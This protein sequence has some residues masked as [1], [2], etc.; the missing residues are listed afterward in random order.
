MALRELVAADQ[1]AL[2]H[3]PLIEARVM[4]LGTNAALA[5][6]DEADGRTSGKGLRASRGGRIL[7]APF[8]SIALATDSSSRCLTVFR[9]APLDLGT[10][11]FFVGPDGRALARW[12]GALPRDDDPVD[13]WLLAGLSAGEHGRLIRFLLQTVRS[14]FRLDDDSRFAAT[15]LRLLNPGGRRPWTLQPRCL[16]TAGFA[17]ASA[18]I[19]TPSG[20]LGRALSL[21]AE[22]V[23]PLTA[24]AAVI[25]GRRPGRATLYLPIPTVPSD[26]RSLIAFPG[27]NGMPTAVPG[28]IGPRLPSFLGWLESRRTDPVR[29]YLAGVLAM[30]GRSDDRAAAAARE[31][32]ICL[33]F[34]RRRAAKAKAPVSGDV[35][36]AIGHG[37]GGLFL[38]GWLSDPHD[39]VEAV[40]AVAPDGRRRCLP[41]PDPFIPRPEIVRKF[42]A[43]DAA[44]AGARL[45]FVVYGAGEGG[46]GQGLQHRFAF[47]LR[48][49]ALV[50]GTAPPQPTDLAAARAAVLA[51][52]PAAH[53]DVGTLER[54]IAPAVAAL[55]ARHMADRPPATQVVFGQPPARPA[56]SVIIPLYRNLDFLRFQIA[57]FAIDPAFA[58]TELIYVLDSPEQRE[59]VEHLLTGLFGLYGLPIRLIVM[60][61]NYGYAAA[62]NAGCSVA[63][64]ERL[65]FLN[66]DVVP[67]RP[68][69]LPLLDRAVASDPQVAAAGA[70]LLFDD[71]SLQHAGLYFGRDWQGRW[72]NR[73]FHK[74]M[75][76][77]FPPACRARSVPAVTGACLLMRRNVYE[78]VG[79]FT[80]DYIIGDYEDSDLCLKARAI[81]YDIRYEPAAELY[82]LERQSIE[83]H[84]GYSRGA[85]SEYNCWLHGKRWAADIEALMGG[86]LDDSDK[87]VA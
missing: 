35:E 63:C 65:L 47:R 62:N 66:S 15:C 31:L 77:H 59:T 6:W 1:L 14:L 49:G 83:Q 2:D 67:D 17:L 21:G 10:P 61:R 57:A 32:Q 26:G 43:K 40:E 50:E 80:E 69:W 73:H 16:L 19:P 20:P 75:P 72:L 37:V 53:L 33:P 4:A 41:R 60:P 9:F 30:L 28:P 46:H 42:V 54:C 29:E 82:H 84:P 86:G 70:K 74:G 55:H 34:V 87:A 79:G 78:A 51:S 27:A 52:V 8:A 23:R 39:L 58:E 76:R 68:G 85:A 5:A 22:G 44:P 7:P 18:E 12:V 25:A 13:V 38:A 56:V 48:S 64:G 11:V 45:G 81:G 24:P 36:L 71:G 3:R